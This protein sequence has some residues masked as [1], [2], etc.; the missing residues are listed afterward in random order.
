M[1]KIL[2]YPCRCGGKLKKSTCNVEFF[3]IDFG[4][5]ECEV[6]TTCGSEYLDDEVIREVEEE[7]KRLGL[8]GLEK[9]KA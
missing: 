2:S 3:R 5:R 8:F 6:C 1:E 4:V 9:E 7:V